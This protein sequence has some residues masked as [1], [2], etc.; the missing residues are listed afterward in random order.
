MPAPRTGDE[1]QTERFGF[2]VV[3]REFG[4]TILDA[5]EKLRIGSG[6]LFT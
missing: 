3:E 4:R 2:A 6:A 5:L 1:F